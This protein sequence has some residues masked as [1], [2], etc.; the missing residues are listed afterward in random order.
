[1]KEVVGSS[2]LTAGIFGVPKV[3]KSTLINIL[4]GRHS[5]ST[6][7]Y[8]GLPGYTKRAQVF[9]IGGDVYL[10][11]TPVLVPPEVVGI[12]ANIRMTQIDNLDNPVA[13]SI[14][15]IKKIL[16]HN[17]AAF[18][19]AYGI[20]VKDP[21][22]ILRTLA[23]KRGWVY[24]KDKEPLLHESAKAIIRDYLE[25]RIPYYTMPPQP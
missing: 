10:G 22:D 1:M 18:E 4:K 24:R 16:E 17:P 8:P 14:E 5:A 25:G 2:P 21:G 20:D 7:P 12:E 9:K 13:V 6:S 3:G 23:L 11:D 15:L 19:E